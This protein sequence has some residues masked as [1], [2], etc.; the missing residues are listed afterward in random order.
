MEAAVVP[1]T[2]PIPF[3]SREKAKS[4]PGKAEA[5]TVRSGSATVAEGQTSAGAGGASGDTSSRGRT[6]P[7]ARQRLI[8]S[9]ETTTRG[10]TN[11]LH[12]GAINPGC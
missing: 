10:G 11:I 8:V 6:N 7:A 2:F 9:G 4:G 1:G 5:P 12:V 3:N